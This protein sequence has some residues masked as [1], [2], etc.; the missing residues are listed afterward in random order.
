MDSNV[1]SDTLGIDQI[2]KARLLIFPG[3]PSAIE[4]KPMLTY[5]FYSLY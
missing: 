1:P 4:A 3:Y 5:L 2:E